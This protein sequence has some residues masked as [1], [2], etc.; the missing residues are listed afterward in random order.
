MK[1]LLPGVLTL[2]VAAS[3]ASAE[4]AVSKTL[5]LVGSGL[6]TVDT[7]KGTIRTGSAC[8]GREPLD[9]KVK[10]RDRPSLRAAPSP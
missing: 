6:V 10:A 2:L 8:H 4:R 9:G 5:P 3:P 1:H 7:Y